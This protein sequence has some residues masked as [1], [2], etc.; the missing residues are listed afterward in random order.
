MKICI[1]ALVV[2]VPLGLHLI[3]RAKIKL[4]VSKDK[5]ELSLTVDL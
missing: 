5:I 3:R 2:L 4:S 1:A